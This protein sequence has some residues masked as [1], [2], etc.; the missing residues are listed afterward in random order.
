MFKKIL[1]LL[2]VFIPLLFTIVF[3]YPVISKKEYSARVKSNPLLNYSKRCYEVNDFTKFIK[4]SKNSN[5]IRGIQLIQTI[6][7]EV[8]NM[9]NIFRGLF[10]L[11]F[12]LQICFCI[13]IFNEHV[14]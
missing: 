13:S 2:I 9:N 8:L 5:K 14:N 6:N 3:G 7:Y 11:I 1:L 10:L 12:I 4:C